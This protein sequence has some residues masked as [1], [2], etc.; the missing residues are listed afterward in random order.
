MPLFNNI[1]NG[2]QAG[3]GVY[4]AV[5]QG[6]AGGGAGGACRAPSGCFQCQMV[7]R[8][9]I[10]GCIDI[11]AAEYRR[12]EAQGNTANTLV[13]AQSALAALNNSS[14]FVQSNDAYLTQAKAVMQ[15]AVRALEAQIT[16]GGGTTGNTTTGN[17][18]TV[19]V[20]NANGQIV[21][22]PANTQTVI[23]GIP[24]SYLVGGGIAILALVY[25]LKK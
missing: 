1:L 16:A 15:N 19:S 22:V 6:Q 13:A 10:A 20:L 8:G 18:G 21:Q 14:F 2:I 9:D 11:L 17:G 5:Q 3:L 7:G 4:G 24:N 12:I 25:F 23:N